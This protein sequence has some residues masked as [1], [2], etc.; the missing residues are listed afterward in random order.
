MKRMKSFASHAKR[1][2][3]LNVYTDGRSIEHL[4]KTELFISVSKHFA[5]SKPNDSCNNKQKNTVI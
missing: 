4:K 5:K 2:Y 3:E 1:L